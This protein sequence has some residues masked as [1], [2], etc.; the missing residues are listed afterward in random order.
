MKGIKRK[1]AYGFTNKAVAKA[2]EK[3]NP[4]MKLGFSTKRSRR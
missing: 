2:R 3:I 1:I 4:L